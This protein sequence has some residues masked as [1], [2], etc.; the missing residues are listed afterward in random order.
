MDAG[1]D[2]AFA[3]RGHVV[4]SRQPARTAV[5]D[6]RVP[7]HPANG[8]NETL[9]QGNFK[10]RLGSGGTPKFPQPAEHCAV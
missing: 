2:S 10:A 5:G 8:S 4:D 6:V 9:A 1:R 7:D 3:R